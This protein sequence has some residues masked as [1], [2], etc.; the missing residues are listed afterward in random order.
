[1]TQ[2]VEFWFDYV[3]PNAYF[4]AMQLPELVARHQARLV[5]R[6]FLLGGL[7]KQLGVP[8]MPGMTSPAKATA[9]QLDLLRWSKK[10]GVPFAFP[11]RFPLNTI[12]ALRVTLA[13]QRGGVD[14]A[15][16]IQR[17]FRAY[18]VEDA[19]LASEPALLDLLAAEGLDGP[20]LLAQAAR[21]E[22]KQALRD[23]TDAATSA[24]LFGAP[25]FVVAGELYFGKD[26]LDFVEDAL[27]RA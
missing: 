21:P 4:A 23:A 14:P 18:W 24:G 9:G 16:F 3:S 12:T 13:L 7:F 17:C 2:T 27:R 19:D 10:Y 15:P 22:G 1:M 25:S 26:R 6:P 8:E 11:S 5:Y 20:Q